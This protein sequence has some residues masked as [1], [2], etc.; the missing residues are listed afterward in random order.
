M[1]SSGELLTPRLAVRPPSEADRDRFVELFGDE[2]FMVFSSG[3]LTNEA[4]HRRFEHMLAV[5]EVVFAKQPVVERGSGLVIGYTGVDYFEFEN[6][7]RLG[8]GYRI[9]PEFRGRGYATEARGALLE[10]A[11]GTFTGEC[12]RSSIRSTTHRRTSAARSASPTGRRRSSMAS[13]GTST[14]YALRRVITWTEPQRGP[15]PG[16]GGSRDRASRP[17]S[18]RRRFRHP[19]A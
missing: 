2:A 14:R 16:I 19:H 9:A 13:T 11:G 8:W 1:P 4:S 12:W 6:E 17:G 10:L 3:P 18:R 15:P 5:A 7:T